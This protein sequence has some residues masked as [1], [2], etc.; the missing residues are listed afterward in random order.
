MMLIDTH[1]HLYSEQFDMDRD[2]MLQRAIEAGVTKFFLPAVDSHSTIAM[3]DLEAK[4]PNHCVA[5]MGL[6]PCS[7]KENYEAE[8]TLVQDWLWK[9]PFCA[10]GEI[11]L[12]LYWDKTFFEQQKIA[13][14]QQIRWAKALNLPIVIHSR[15][16]TWEVISILQSEKDEKLCGIFHCFGGNL[17]EATAIIELGFY[18]G[19]GGVLT[20][21]KSGL[22]ETLQY[23]D[24]QHVVL[25]TDAP[26]LA[27]VPF[28]GKRNES[29]YLR[30][31]AEKLAKVKGVSL[32]EVAAITSQNARQIFNQYTDK[33]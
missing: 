8:L 11:G 29:G 5:M 31:I 12:D 32:E 20:F 28:R 17:E 26:Y 3:L 24:L 21:K 16:S 19:I 14:T 6:H 30:W 23:V 33:Q 10:V 25:E 13:F 7:V 22:E 1:T 9:R 18:L 2:D 27:P 15:E 4:Y